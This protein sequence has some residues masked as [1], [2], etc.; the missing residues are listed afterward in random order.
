MDWMR[1]VIDIMKRRVFHAIGLKSFWRAPR[2]FSFDEKDQYDI[3]GN[4]RNSRDRGKL[5]RIFDNVSY[6]LPTT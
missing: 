4:S 1:H 6:S 2:Y 3:M 5:A